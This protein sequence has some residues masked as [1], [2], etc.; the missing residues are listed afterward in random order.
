MRFFEN[1]FATEPVREVKGKSRPTQR[2]SQKNPLENLKQ[3]WAEGGNE[4]TAVLL[5]I[6]L[7]VLGI[8]RRFKLQPFNISDL[9]ETLEGVPDILVEMKNG[10]FYVIEAKARRYITV[11]VNEK[12]NQI[13]ECMK[14]LGIDYLL[15]NDKDKYGRTNKLN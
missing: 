8:V 14:S 15:W 3:I 1:A 10:R 12:L 5:L 4:H 6:H 9:D 2:F 11:E 7:E 13:D